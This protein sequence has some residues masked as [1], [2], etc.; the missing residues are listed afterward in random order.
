[1][2]V[3]VVAMPGPGVPGAAA[4]PNHG[5]TRFSI[6][7]DITAAIP[8]FRLH[9]IYILLRIP[10]YKPW[11]EQVAHVNAVNREFAGCTCQ[12]AIIAHFSWR[13]I[14]AG[15]GPAAVAGTKANYDVRELN[16]AVNP[17]PI[18]PL[19]ALKDIVFRSQGPW[20]PFFPE[21]TFD[22]VKTRTFQ[23]WRKIAPLTFY[24]M[25]IENSFWHALS[26]AL[27]TDEK[28]WA[29]IKAGVDAY[30]NR[31]LI[32]PG[33]LRVADYAALDAYAIARGAF[34]GGAAPA[35]PV[36]SFAQQLA[37]H[38]PP[39]PPHHVSSELW[40]VVADAF[41]IEL[42]VIIAQPIPDGQKLIV[43]RGQH[44]RRQV[45]LLL[46]TDGEYRAAQPE[47]RDPCSY[48]FEWFKDLEHNI[49]PLDAAQGASWAVAINI[50][51][52]KR[53]PFTIV[54]NWQRPVGVP[55]M[56]GV[57]GGIPP[58]VGPFVP[59]TPFIHDEFGPNATNAQILANLNSG[60]WC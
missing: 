53:S 8:N 30:Y 50:S 11:A 44:N 21:D 20:G 52:E 58:Y 16:F 6:I 49:L 54:D 59:P 12:G 7:A 28:Y 14:G 26:I 4:C 32:T 41:D 9:G 17:P 43:P 45:F 37:P 51:D 5:A 57:V 47:S 56:P 10:I 27:Y 25:H 19:P 23:R 29:E 40:Q 15:A 39:A 13:I 33:H 31:V 18:F 48:R 55:P 38:V 1:M 2:A 60:N 22:F 42:L 34:A 24:C 35:Q 3:V 36:S 46:E